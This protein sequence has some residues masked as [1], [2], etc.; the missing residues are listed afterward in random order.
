MEWLAWLW[1]VPEG[2]GEDSSSVS[3]LSKGISSRL[4]LSTGSESSRE[5]PEMEM[6]RHCWGPAS[7]SAEGAGSVE[8]LTSDSGRSLSEK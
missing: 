8:G 7:S 1:R 3:S 6:C 5:E 2:L 4:A